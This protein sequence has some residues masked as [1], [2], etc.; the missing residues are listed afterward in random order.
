M[1]DRRFHCYG[2]YYDLACTRPFYIGKG[3]T[4]REQHWRSLGVNYKNLNLTK[5]I[6]KV[7]A[8]HGF[9]PTKILWGNLSSKQASQTERR[10]ITQIGRY[11]NG[12]LLN[13]RNGG[14]GGP[15]KRTKP[16][17]NK[18][19]TMSD[20][21]RAKLRAAWARN[22]ASRHTDKSRA[23]MS[24]SLRRAYADPDTRAYMAAEVKA[25]LANPEW[26]AAQAA[27]VKAIWARR[28]KLID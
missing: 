18:G 6:R 11:P 9:V 25:A 16:A 12:P 21:Q 22:P 23:K 15:F 26:R 20:A 5:T 28:K 4:R 13:I 19:Q 3:G 2:W 24:Q 17:H 1:T 27:R 14:N 10:L 7:V 8:D